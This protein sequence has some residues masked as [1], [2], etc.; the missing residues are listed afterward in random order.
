[1]NVFFPDP[2][3]DTDR[4]R[5]QARADVELA[6]QRAEV[7]YKQISNAM[8]ELERIQNHSGLKNPTAYTLKTYFQARARV[9]ELTAQLNEL[10]KWWQNIELN[11]R[12]L[13]CVLAEA[14]VKTYSRLTEIGVRLP[15]YPTGG[16]SEKAEF[17]DAAD[18]YGC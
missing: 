15:P 3:S 7:L 13:D 17:W 9:A 10:P 5:G 16:W 2:P 11:L 12:S 6:A 18:K 8:R 4:L 1:M 14:S